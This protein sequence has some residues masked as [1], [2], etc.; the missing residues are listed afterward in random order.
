MKRYLIIFTLV[1]IVIGVTLG[2]LLAKPSEHVHG[3]SS[4][5]SS[6]DPA[7]EA[8]S[9]ATGSKGQT[10]TYYIAADEVKWDYAPSGKNL[11]TGEEF[12]EQ[13]KVFVAPGQDRIGKVYLKS[14]YQEYTDASFKT[15]KAIPAKWKHKGIL[16]PVIEAEVGDT[17]VV[18][19]KNNT[20][21]PANMHP[22]GVFYE[23]N[24]EGALY[25]DGTSGADKKDDS[26]PPGGTVT[27]TWGVPERAGPGPM[28]PSSVIWMYHGH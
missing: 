19:F 15:L 5:E 9:T 24:S 4:H 21:F 8:A 13:A 10:R 12:D 17:I 20:A 26:V 27:Y 7:P 23:K 11:I 22:H 28:D 25:D 14:Q 2:L 18:V 16:G 1:G 3:S 6:S